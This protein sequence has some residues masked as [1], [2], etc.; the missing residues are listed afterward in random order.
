MIDDISR[1]PQESARHFGHP[2]RQRFAEL[3]RGSEHADRLRS[4][5]TPIVVVPIAYSLS[6]T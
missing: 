6:L 2:R 4:D 5:I 1:L 3:L